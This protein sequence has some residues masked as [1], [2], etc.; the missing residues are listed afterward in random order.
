VN[1]GWRVQD[2]GLPPPVPVARDRHGRNHR[3]IAHRIIA[4]RIIAHLV[5]IHRVTRIRRII[6]G[7]LHAVI[8]L[9]G[10]IRGSLV[11]YRTGGGR[12]R[13]EIGTSGH[14]RLEGRA[15]CLRLRFG[16]GAAWRRAAHVAAHR[17]AA[18]NWPRRT[19]ILTAA[20]A[21]FMVEV[22]AVLT[23]YNGVERVIRTRT[24]IMVK[25]FQQPPSRCRRCTKS[26]T[27]KRQHAQRKDL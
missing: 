11:K 16:T 13:G 25:A 10:A 6:A 21:T 1:E 15:R 5:G 17:Q 14:R 19:P 7:R 18:A 20:A 8:P 9:G 24:R 27:G 23:V 26:P 4:H 2:L 3:V 22:V 12:R